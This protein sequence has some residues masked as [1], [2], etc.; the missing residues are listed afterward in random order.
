MR[1]GQ[2]KSEWYICNSGCGVDAVLFFLP[3]TISISHHIHATCTCNQTLA[4][5]VSR[6]SS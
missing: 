1:Q 3:V 5:S 6:S 2:G 4:V